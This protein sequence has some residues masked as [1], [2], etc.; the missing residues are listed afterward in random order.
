MQLLYNY[1]VALCVVYKDCNLPDANCL[2][3]VDSGN[4]LM[5]SDLTLLFCRS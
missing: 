1:S 5:Y 3:F 4:A 2:S